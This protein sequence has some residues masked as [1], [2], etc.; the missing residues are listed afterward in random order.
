MVRAVAI[1]AD[2]NRSEVVT[3]SYIVD[4]QDTSVYQ[5]LAFVSLI[6]DPSYLFDKEDGIYVM[7]EEYEKL[8][9][10]AGGDWELV[11]AQPNYERSGKCS[12]RDAFIE[13]Y[14]ANH[15]PLLKQNIGLR[16]H[17]NSTRNMSQ[18]SFSIYAREM[19]DGNDKFISDVFGKGNEYHKFM[20]VTDYDETKTRQHFHARLLEDRAVAVQDF[21]RAN[22]FLNGEY[23]GV[24]WIAEVYN[25][26]YIENYYG[27]PKEE[28]LIEDGAWP[29]ELL[30]IAEN[31]DYEEMLDKID[32]QSF[33]DYY[34]AMIY[35]DHS[36]WFPQNTYMWKSLT[37]SED[38]PYQ[39]GKWRWMVYDTDACENSFDSDTFEKECTNEPII[40][41]LMLSDDFCKQFTENFMDMANT[42]FEVEHVNALLDEVFEEYTCAMY[43]QESRWGDDWSGNMYERVD[44]IK[45]FY[46]NRYDYIVERL[47]EVFK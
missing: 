31:G 11:D 1:D 30:E 13:V 38:N 27:I 43:A 9:I 4:I 26:E 20:L 10:E 25:E 19:Y 17:G 22:V 45:S 18:K 36:D 29:D 41:T 14:N 46:V 32:L 2:G 8:L 37:I 35:I 5:G 15:E 24:Y 16:I 28:V 40:N 44:M 39:D 6:T 12:E 34:G 21:I 23:W 42:V 3:Q 33:M 47:G 7:G